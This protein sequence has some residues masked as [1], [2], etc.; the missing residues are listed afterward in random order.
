[1]DI[2]RSIRVGLA[3]RK[4]TSK[5]LADR[6]GISESYLSRLKQGYKVP[7]IQTLDL[8]AASLEYRVSEFIALGED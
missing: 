1:M 8:I 7:T 5:D 6:V 3:C 2:S 4:V